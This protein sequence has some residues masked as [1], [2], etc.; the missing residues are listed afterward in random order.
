MREK[1]ELKI[2]LAGCSM[3]RVFERQ[4]IEINNS[5]KKL[6]DE[7]KELLDLVADMVVSI[8]IKET[9]NQCLVLK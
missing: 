5:N 1:L 6:S 7:E 2:H 3:C 4:S 9:E 8:I